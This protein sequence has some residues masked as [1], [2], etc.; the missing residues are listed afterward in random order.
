MKRKKTDSVKKL[1]RDA[2]EHL[3]E[4]M[5]GYRKQRANLM[6]EIS[7]DKKLVKEIRKVNGK[8]K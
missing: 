3:H 2:I 5:S 7:E 1:H 6:K 8:S 4:D